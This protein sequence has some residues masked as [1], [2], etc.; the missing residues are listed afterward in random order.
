MTISMPEELATYLRS[1]RKTSSVIAEAVEAY[2][3]REL[4]TEL[5]EAY[6]ADADEAERLNREW[7]TIDAEIEE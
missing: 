1:T 5:E 7:E 3:A 6:L 2:R 4:E